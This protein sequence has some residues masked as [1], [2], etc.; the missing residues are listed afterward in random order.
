MSELN[1]IKKMDKVDWVLLGI[2][3]FIVFMIIFFVE[4]FEEDIFLFSV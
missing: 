4:W 3:F 2:Y 1:W